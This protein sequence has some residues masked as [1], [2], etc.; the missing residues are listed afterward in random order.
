MEETKLIKTIRDIGY[1]L[2]S[3]EKYRDFMNY[4]RR[5]LLLYVL[6]LV[7]FSGIF[8]TSIPLAGFM[9][10]GGL[11]GL[12][13]EQIPEFTA[14]SE[15]GFWID[16]PVEIDEYNFLIKANSDMVYEDITDLNGQ[17][18][19]YDYAIIVDKEQ[20]YMKTLGNEPL[21]ARFD[22]MTDFSFTKADV[23]SFV[24]MMYM[25]AFFVFILLL[26]IDY[27]YYF[28]TA[29]VVSWIAGI[30]A[31]FMRIR[32]GNKKL[33][34]MAVYAGTMSYLLVLVQSI[35]GISIPNFS[36]FSMIIS[37]GYMYFALKEY[38]ESII[39]ELPPEQFGGR[40]DNL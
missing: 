3:P 40:E 15:D 38:K 4:K 39:E 6:I 34:N 25:A 7:L 19:S 12:L 11:K 29:F 30:I 13:T 35:L 28:I 21:T 18:G 36:F 1:A 10:D 33:F 32:L 9:A 31:S 2:T 20:L 14:S 27:G 22:Q 23:L 37:L 5:N 24:P 16:E 26:V 17:Y 8:S